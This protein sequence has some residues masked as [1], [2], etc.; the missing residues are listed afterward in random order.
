MFD[1]Q[2]N[3]KYNGL[4]YRSLCLRACHLRLCAKI[5][6]IMRNTYDLLNHKFWPTCLQS[7]Q[8]LAK[9]GTCRWSPGQL[10]WWWSW[11]GEMHRQCCGLLH[12]V[13]FVGE[14]WVEE[15]LPDS[16]MRRETML[17]FSSGTSWSSRTRIAIMAA[18]PVATVASWEARDG[19]HGI[20]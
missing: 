14:E 17:M 7:F 20:T 2:N 8:F 6:E 18:A 19:G 11:H 4:C 12:V 10:L 13:V 5:P 16:A 3:T 15:V 9:H 1:T